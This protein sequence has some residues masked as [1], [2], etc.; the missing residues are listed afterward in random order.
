MP[1]L[2]QREQSVRNAAFEANVLFDTGETVGR[3]VCSPK[4]EATIE[5]QQ[6]SAGEFADFDRA[7]VG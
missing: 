6:W 4:S 5:Q 7:V 1:G 3:I 2:V